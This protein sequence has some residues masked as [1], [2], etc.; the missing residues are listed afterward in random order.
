M[1]KEVGP[2]IVNNLVRSYLFIQEQPLSNALHL[3]DH[4]QATNVLVAFPKIKLCL[5][6]V[7][8][9]AFNLIKHL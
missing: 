8:I 1:I 9:M 7:H 5:L 2:I 3:S 4:G 6:G